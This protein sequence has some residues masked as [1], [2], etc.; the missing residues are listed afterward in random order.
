MML[1]DLQK[2][3]CDKNFHL[4]KMVFG[5]HVGFLQNELPQSLHFVLYYRDVNKEINH[6]L[7]SKVGKKD[8]QSIQH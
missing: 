7:G 4:M 1:K 5:G 3:F 2:M 8:A 6:L